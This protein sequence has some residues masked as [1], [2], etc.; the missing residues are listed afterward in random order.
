VL[1]RVSG[2]PARGH[3]Q[4]PAAVPAPHALR[5]GSEG[6]PSSRSQGAA[7]RVTV[8]PAMRPRTGTSLHQR[9]AVVVGRS[10]QLVDRLPAPCLG[11][12]VLCV[13]PTRRRSLLFLFPCVLFSCRLVRVTQDRVAKPHGVRLHP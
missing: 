12:P 6:R 3:R 1:G 11:V 7:R 2:S 5:E 8:V 4:V 10:A 9:G 13:P